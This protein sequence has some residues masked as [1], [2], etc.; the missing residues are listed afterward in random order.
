MPRVLWFAVP[1]MTHE[2]LAAISEDL[3]TAYPWDEGIV[4]LQKWSRATWAP[5][6]R[7]RFVPVGPAADA[8]G[9]GFYSDVA[10]IR[11][12]LELE[13]TTFGL[14]TGEMLPARA[15]FVEVERGVHQFEHTGDVND[16]YHLSWCWPADAP[17]R[18][19]I[20]VRAGCRT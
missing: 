19:R 11:Y 13:K 16:C 4:A 20:P 7:A 10:T 1:M 6:E 14:E 18:V 12:S 9:A 3:Q 17:N 15:G 8:V 5:T 2:S